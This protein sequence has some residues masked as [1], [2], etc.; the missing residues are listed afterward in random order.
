MTRKVTKQGHNDWADLRGKT[1]QFEFQ[2]P[3][4]DDSDWVI[5]EFS[6]TQYYHEDPR[7]PRYYVLDKDGG[8]Y[9]FWDDDEVEVE[10]L[11]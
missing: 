8:G 4:E 1:V 5:L 2:A 11:D 9:S 10:I 6:H 7:Y 3:W